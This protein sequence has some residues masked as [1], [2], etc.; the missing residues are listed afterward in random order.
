VRRG[1]EELDDPQPLEVGRSRVPG[2]GRKR[3]GGLD[4]GLAGALGKLVGPE[5]RGDPMTPLRWTCKSLRTLAGQLRAEGHQ[6][7]ASLVQRL[8]HEAGCSLQANAKTLE[9]SQHPGRDA[10]FR[11]I[12]DTAARFLPAGDPVV[13]VDA[14]KK[15]LARQAPDQP[16]DDHQPD[17]R[18]H[19]NHRAD[20]HR[21][22]RHRPCPTGVKVSGRQVKN[23]PI[24]RDPWHGEWNYA[25][26]ALSVL[27]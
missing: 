24:T 8:W 23:L 2:G 3:A 4:P 15:E 9:G 27:A 7:S 18:H 13:S 22:A 19:R 5:T 21:P 6:V 12:H 20:R 26:S 14:K 16:R 11:H 1:R 17:R 25:I 10:Q